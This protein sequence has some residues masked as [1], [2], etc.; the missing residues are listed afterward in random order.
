MHVR[1]WAIVMEWVPDNA[2]N[3]IEY[4][5]ASLEFWV[6]RAM[7]GDVNTTLATLG[8]CLQNPVN[9]RNLFKL[10]EFGRYKTCYGVLQEVYQLS[11]RNKN[12]S[13]RSISDVSGTEGDED[14]I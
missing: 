4:I 7:W 8:Q 11:E 3:S 1:N 5:R 13:S 10:V 12:K 6:P 9:A 2:H 14:N